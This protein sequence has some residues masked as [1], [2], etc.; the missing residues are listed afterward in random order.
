MGVEV[1]ILPQ[2]KVH[3]FCTNFTADKGHVICNLFRLRHLIL[4]LAQPEHFHVWV[5]D[6]AIMS[7][8]RNHQAVNEQVRI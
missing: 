2:S 4:R 3:F 1:E 8:F 6:K 5:D 7:L